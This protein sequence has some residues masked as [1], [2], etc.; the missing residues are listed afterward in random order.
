LNWRPKGVSSGKTVW[1]A[2]QAMPVWRAKLG[3]ACA[4]GASSVSAATA[5]ASWNLVCNRI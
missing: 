4:T 1:Q 3:T 2:A 5:A